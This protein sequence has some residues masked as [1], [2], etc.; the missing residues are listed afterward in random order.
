MIGITYAYNNANFIITAAAYDQ[1]GYNKLQNLLST[2]I[3][4]FIFAV[5]LSY[6]AGIFFSKKYSVRFR[7]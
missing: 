7:P 3:I 4:V 1:Y 5:F 2:I 6:A